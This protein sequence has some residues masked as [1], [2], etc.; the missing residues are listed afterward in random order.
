MNACPRCHGANVRSTDDGDGLY[1]AH[2]WCGW[3]GDAPTRDEWFE[4]IHEDD[5]ADLHPLKPRGDTP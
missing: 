3:E 5:V 4:G 2:L 1:C